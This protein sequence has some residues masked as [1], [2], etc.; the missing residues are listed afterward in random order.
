MDIGPTELIIVLIIVVL[1]F[2]PGRIAKVGRE[3]GEGIRQFRSGLDQHEETDTS[4]EDKTPP[5][6]Q[7][8]S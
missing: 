3:L 1:I 5:E 8:N 2:G 7:E 4:E 6:K